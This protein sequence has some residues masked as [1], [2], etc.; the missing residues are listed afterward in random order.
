MS[1][2]MPD[3]PILVL[4]GLAFGDGL[5]WHE[6]RIWLCDVHDDLVLSVGAEGDPKIEA[7]LPGRPSGIAILPDGTPL[8][9]VGKSR[10]LFRIESSGPVLHADLSPMVRYDLH[11]LAVTPEGR[12]YVGNVGFDQ[13]SGSDPASTTLAC[14]ETD[15]SAWIVAERL[16][17]PN[18]VTVTPDGSTV[19]VAETFGNRI[20]AYRITDDGSL[21]EPREWADLRP[22]VPTG[23]TLDAEGCLW[24]ADPIGQG[25]MR[26]EEGRG[27]TSWID[28]PFQPYD[29]ALG[30]EEGRTLFIA[31]AATSDPSRSQE[32]R[33]GQVLALEVEVPAAGR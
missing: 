33:S 30:G 32:S 13:E 4:G 5:H 15:G 22:N 12:A 16:L 27:A 11:G 8:V 24:V 23:T 21:D 28:L 18:G 2:E 26:V 25:V 10:Q 14:V 19:L 20:S 6:G 7:E 9:T 31:T 17:F 3:E 1:D 29:C